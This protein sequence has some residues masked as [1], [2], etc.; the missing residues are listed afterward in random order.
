MKKHA[1]FLG[2]AHGLMT[3]ACSLLLPACSAAQ[4]INFSQFYELPLLRNPALAGTYRG[5]VRITTAFRNQWNSVTVPYQTEALGAELKFGVSENSD[6]YLSLGVQV[7]N[8]LA[9]DSRLGKTQVLP[10]LAFHKSVSSE[11]AAY[12]SLGFRVVPFS[13]A[14]TRPSCVSTTSL[15]AG[16]TVPPIPHTMCLPKPMLLTG[17]RL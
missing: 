14:L 6:D 10:M 4:D 17:M 3:V 9:G 15:L 2:I 7:T 8:D 11:K 13:N 5:D 12:L 16:L 1:G